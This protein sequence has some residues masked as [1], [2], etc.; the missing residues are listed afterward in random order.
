MREVWN[1][2]VG[3]LGLV[4]AVIVIGLILRYGRSTVGIL[5]TAFSGLEHETQI[6]TLSGGA[7]NYPY[8]GM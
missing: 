8:Y 7:A 4:L 2:V 5:S 6:L 1:D 3:L